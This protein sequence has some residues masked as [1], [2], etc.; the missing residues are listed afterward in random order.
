[1]QTHDIVVIGGSAGALRPVQNILR[2]LPA[3]L[4]AAVFL[5]IHTPPDSS[6]VLP[7]VLSKWGTL[8][9]QNA[10]D[11]E[12]IRAGRV[13]V[14]P[15]DHHLLVHRGH[16]SVTRGPRENR[17][18][19]AVD[20]LFRTAA[21]AYGPRVIG[22]ILS[23]GQDDGAAGLAHIKRGGGVAIA[24]DPGDADAPSMPDSAI[25]QVDVDHVLSAEN[26]AAV[27]AGLV[28]TPVEEAAMS[29]NDEPRDPAETGTNALHTGSLP[30]PPSGF[31]CP[32]CGGALWE[33]RDGE[34]VRFQCHVGHGF[35]ADS[36][37]AAHSDGL[38]MALWTA[39]RALEESAALRRRM[40]DHARKR[41]MSAIAEA[42][43][44]HALDS[45]ARAQ[46]IRRVLVSGKPG[47]VPEP[48]TER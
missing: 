22:V 2:R 10:S 13:Y 18:R 6:G 11:G 24:Q 9:A 28:Q 8:P 45:E 29:A 5:V 48:L 1:V 14:A 34:L 26:I 25:R 40:A 37:L 47:R 21:A 43:E 3:G 17:F 7:A 31:V 15:P 39:L 20:P 4:P 44:E 32:E 16:M 33:V 46:I 19:P 35:S 42:Y 38:D 27:I 30:G 36:L 23:G 41:G 12:Q